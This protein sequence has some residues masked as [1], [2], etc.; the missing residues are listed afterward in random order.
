MSKPMARKKQYIWVVR[1]GIIS[2]TDRNSLANRVFDICLL[3]LFVIL[4]TTSFV[5]DSS[6]AELF[7]M[8]GK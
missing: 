3:V 6:S 8:L 7:N 2:R 1:D 5:G 4:A